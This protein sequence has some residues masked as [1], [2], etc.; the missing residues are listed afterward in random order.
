M[1]VTKPQHL[2]DIYKSTME[3][4]FFYLCP[5]WRP[6]TQQRKLQLIQQIYLFLLFQPLTYSGREKTSD[7]KRTREQKC[8]TAS[9]LCLLFVLP[10]MTLESHPWIFHQPAGLLPSLSSLYVPYINV[11]VCGAVRPNG[12]LSSARPEAGNTGNECATVANTLE[13]DELAFA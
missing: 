13:E 9:F 11:C 10:L 2:Q 3:M 1:S 5:D 12:H 8:V 4:F 6:S 7:V